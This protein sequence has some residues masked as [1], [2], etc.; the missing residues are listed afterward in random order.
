MREVIPDFGALIVK[1]E[2]PG[3][4]STIGS[5]QLTILACKMRMNISIH[6]KVK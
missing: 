2:L 1:S 3:T 6:L 4:C 5:I